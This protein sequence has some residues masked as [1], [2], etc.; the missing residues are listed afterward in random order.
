MQEARAVNRFDWEWPAITAT[1]MDGAERI[2]ID[3]VVAFSD[4]GCWP[5]PGEASIAA[6]V[7][8]TDGKELLRRAA[9]IGQGT[10]N[11]AE[12][13]AIRLGLEMCL[14]L[15]ARRVRFHSD[16]TLAING[17]TKNSRHLKKP[18][19]CALRD[20]IRDELLPLFESVTFE[21]VPREH[22]WIS[23]ADAMASEVRRR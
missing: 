4:G 1:R 22:P 23:E 18:L 7:L 14:E 2:T 15:G 19:L 21:H 6:I 11:I 13:R 12:Y 9:S 17:I 16:S 5:N 20:A 10:N 8:D 3:E